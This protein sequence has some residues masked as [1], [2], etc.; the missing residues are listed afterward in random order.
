MLFEPASLLDEAHERSDPSAR[1]D[2]DHRV[3]RLEWQ[4]ELGLA[5]VHGDGGL[6]AVDEFV[7]QPVG[8]HALVD[9]ARL[10]LVLHHHGTDMDAVGVNLWGGHILLGDVAIRAT[11]HFLDFS[12]VNFKRVSTLDEEAIE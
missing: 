8:R 3:G 7:F 10:G 5:D 2:H 6:V 12:C 11:S 9:A 1:A 4:S